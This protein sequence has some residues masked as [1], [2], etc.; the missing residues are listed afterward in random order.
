MP[1]AELMK[2]FLRPRFDNY[3]YDQQNP[4]YD[5]MDKRFVQQLWQQHCAGQSKPF[6]KTLGL[7]SSL[8]T[9]EPT[10][11]KEQHFMVEKQTNLFGDRA[12]L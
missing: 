3:F 11:A 7:V 1:L 6:E 12:A 10:K 9:R 2:G 5:W 8:G 4:V